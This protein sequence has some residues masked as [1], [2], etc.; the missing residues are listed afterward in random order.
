MSRLRRWT[1]VDRWDEEVY[2]ISSVIYRCMPTT[3]WKLSLKKIQWWFLSIVKAPVVGNLYV[4]NVTHKSFSISW[5]G[6]ERGFEGFILEVID[7]SWQKEPVEVNISQNTMSHDITG[8]EPRTDYIAYLYGVMRGRRTHAISTVATT[9]I[10]SFF[11]ASWS[12]LISFHT[13]C[14]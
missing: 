11:F 14:I 2:A 4:S 8:L 12:P 6:T 13:V 1:S 7:T 9:G 3:P 10:S 5:N